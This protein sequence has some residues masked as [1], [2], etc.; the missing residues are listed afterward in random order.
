MRLIIKQ[1]GALVR[2]L[3]FPWR[4]PW[5]N[6]GGH[7]RGVLRQGWYRTC[8]S[9]EQKGLLR[10]VR[11]G[12]HTRNGDL[13]CRGEEGYELTEEGQRLAEELTAPKNPRVVREAMRMS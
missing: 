10:Y 2:L 9:L 8:C 4:A 13:V 3:S 5:R 12:E 7:S 1:K 11:A 6:A